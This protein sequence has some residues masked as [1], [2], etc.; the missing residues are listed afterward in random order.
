MAAARRGKD[1]AGQA[2][3]GKEERYMSAEGLTIAEIS[4]LAKKNRVR[5]EV[6]ITPV[7]SEEKPFGWDVRRV[8]TVEPWEPYEPRCPYGK[9]QT[10]AEA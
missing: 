7:E 9:N 3:T 1:S 8:V 2:G 6:E 4:E 5:I 10:E